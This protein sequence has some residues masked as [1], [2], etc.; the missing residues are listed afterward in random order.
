L[1]S[2][3]SKYTVACNYVS[4]SE[5]QFSAIKFK[6]KT[7]NVNRATLT[8]QFITVATKVTRESTGQPW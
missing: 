5:S 2:S 4:E 6:N 3:R 8:M 1:Y 7:G